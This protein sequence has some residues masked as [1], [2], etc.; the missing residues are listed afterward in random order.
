MHSS[1]IVRASYAPLLE[2][3]I[4]V[5]QLLT[6][7]FASCSVIPPCSPRLQLRGDQLLQRLVP[8]T[9]RDYHGGVNALRPAM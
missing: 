1:V 5:V 8:A 7:P 2:F 3:P 4:V 9:V 6:H